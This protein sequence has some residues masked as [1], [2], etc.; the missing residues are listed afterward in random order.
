M[1]HT[2]KWGPG[3]WSIERW[4]EGE[5]AGGQPWKELV[6]YYWDPQT[7]KIRFLGVSPF[8]EGIQRGT[9]EFAG[10]S[11]IANSTLIQTSGR[12]EMQTRWLFHKDSSYTETLLEK[13]SSGK[14]A[15]LVT[16]QHQRISRNNQPPETAAAQ[17]EITEPFKGLKFLLGNAWNGTTDDQRRRFQTTIKWLPIANCVHATITE[18]TGGAAVEFARVCIYHEP[19][20]ATLH[21]LII[22]ANSEI[23]EGSVHEL[24][25]DTIQLELR[26]RN[27]N[28]SHS[29]KSQFEQKPGGR[30]LQTIRSNGSAETDWRLHHE[31]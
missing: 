15:E 24:S 8:A 12:R 29:I 14:F 1:Y 10:D 17:E 7:G 19:H 9:I 28:K 5:G 30:W 31:R 13:D 2:W 27:Q 25:V 3:K 26:E 23:Y 4:T 16:F 6:V 18:T 11:A 22:C 21:C 20:A